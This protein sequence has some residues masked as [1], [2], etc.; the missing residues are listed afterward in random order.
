MMPCLIGRGEG[1]IVVIMPL[2]SLI[3]GVKRDYD[4]I[5]L[6]CLV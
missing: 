1:M 3:D 5:D 2:I 4:D 6:G